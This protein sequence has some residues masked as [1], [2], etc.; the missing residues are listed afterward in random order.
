MASFPLKNAHFSYPTIHST[1]KLKM[2]PLEYIAEIM[3]ARV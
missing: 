1:P 2:F 3:H